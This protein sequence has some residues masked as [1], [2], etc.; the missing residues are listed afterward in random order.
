ML[1]FSRGLFFF[2]S[3]II[4]QLLPVP[5]NPQ[6]GGSSGG[7]GGSLLKRNG[8]MGRRENLKGGEALGQKEV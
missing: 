3:H 1:S 2:F 4:G 7:K 6:K 8:E 5:A